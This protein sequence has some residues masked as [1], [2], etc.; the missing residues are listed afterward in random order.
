MKA[1]RIQHYQTSSSTNAKGY[2]LDRNKKGCINVNPK[3]TNK[4][5]AMGPYLSIITLKFLAYF[6][7]YN[8]LQFHPCH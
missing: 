2:S 1:E 6:T 8:G 5:M 4:Q 3:Q 7:L